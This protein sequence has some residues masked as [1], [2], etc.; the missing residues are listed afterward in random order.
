MPTC[1][2]S[3]SQT[4]YFSGLLARKD[5]SPWCTG[6]E[7]ASLICL[8]N[9]LF[10]HCYQVTW[11]RQTLH[12]HHC[13]SNLLQCKQWRWLKKKRQEIF[14]APWVCL[15]K[16]GLWTILCI[17]LVFLC[18]IESLKV[19]GKHWIAL[20]ADFTFAK[21]NVKGLHQNVTDVVKMTW[22]GRLVYSPVDPRGVPTIYNVSPQRQGLSC[23]N[24]LQHH[25]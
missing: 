11:N 8:A 2:T 10:A 18:N 1:K 23:A 7:A 4:C 16:M 12:K 24:T 21:H 14:S 17:L 20:E 3:L 9:C 6:S 19:S 22:G 5:T 25:L 13:R 15:M